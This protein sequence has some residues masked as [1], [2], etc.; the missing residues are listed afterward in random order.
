[1]NKLFNT[2]T[3]LSILVS[4]FWNKSNAQSC[5][6]NAGVDQTICVNSTMTL[7]GSSTGTIS[8]AGKWQFISGPNTPTITSPNNATTTVTGIAAGTYVF[9]YYAT[10]VLGGVVTD[11][12]TVFVDPLP[13]FSAGNDVAVC[14]SIAQLNGNLPS[15]A[16][17]V[18]SSSNINNALTT[19]FASPNSTTSNVSL[20]NPSNLCPKKFN[21]IWTVT[22]GGCVLKDTAIVTI[23][24]ASNSFSP[25]TDKT[26]CGATVYSTPEYFYGCG[27]SL[28]GTQL[29][30]PSISSISY[31]SNFSSVNPSN[32]SN[33]IINFGSLIVGTYT[34]AVE[35]KTC[36]GIVFRDTFNVTINSTIGVTNPNI[37][38]LEICPKNFDTVYYF[39]PTVNLL[40]GEVL[41]WNTTPKL[42]LPST[43]PSPNVQVIGNV[44]KIS[45][46]LHP[47][48]SSTVTWFRYFYEY[49]VSNGS[50]SAIRTIS[51]NLVRPLG[52]AT[53]KTQFLPCNTTSTNITQILTGPA[54]PIQYSNAVIVS[55][56]LGAADPTILY[57]GTSITASN[58]KPGKYVISFQYSD[59]INCNSNIGTAEINVSAT[60][61][62]SNAGTDQTLGCGVSSATFAGNTPPTFQTGA[63]QLVSG[64]MN[65]SLLTPSNP[66]LTVSGFSMSG[67][68][69]FRWVISG[70]TNCPVSSDEVRILV[71]LAPPSPVNAGPDTTICSG[72]PIVLIGTPVLPIETALWTQIG[73][74]TVFIV[75]PTSETTAITGVSAGTKDTFTYAKTN[76]C[77]TGKDTVII[78][79]SSNIGP[80]AATITTLDF[81]A[82]GGVT[83]LPIAA[84][85]PSSGTGTWSI[86]SG[87]SAI[88]AAPSLSSTSVN[89][90]GGAGIY[91]L[92]W[93]VS[94]AGGCASQTDILTISYNGGLSINAA[95][96][97]DQT[98][99]STAGLNLA[100][101][102]PTSPLLGLWTQSVGPSVNINSPSSNTSAVTGLTESVY[103][104]VWTVSAGTESSCPIGRDTVHI[105]VNAPPTVSNIVT[106][107]K[108]FCS[109][110]N[111]TLAISANSPVSG[112]GS[113]AL[114]QTPGPFT[115]SIGNVS[116]P[117]TV[118]NYSSGIT[119]AIW[120]ISNGA[121]PV[122]IDTLTV[123]AVAPISAGSNRSVCNQNIFNLTGSILGNGSATWTLVSGPTI[124]V[125]SSPN[126]RVTSV[127]NLSAGT[128]IFRYSVAHP[129]CAAGFADVTINNYAQPIAK[130]GLDKALC[131]VT[132][133][134]PIALIA[135][136]AGG[137]G[138][139]SV[140]WT[141]TLGAGTITFSPN[142]NS[143]I[144]TA[145]AN[146]FGL[147]QFLLT[148]SNAACISKDYIDVT[149]IKPTINFSFSALTACNKDFTVFASVPTSGYTFAWSF[150]TGATTT[151]SSTGAITNSFTRTGPNK[152]Y[153]TITSP[154]PEFCSLTDSLTIDVCKS[155]YPPIANNITA[156]PINSSNGPTQI[157]QLKASNPMGTPI[158]TYKVLTLPPTSQ[159]VL[160][161]CASAPAICTPGALTAVSIGSILTPAQ[162][163]SL[164]FDPVQT[165][166]GNVNFTYSAT[167]TNNLVSNVA[168]YSIPVYNNSPTTLNIRTAPVGN[169]SIGDLN[170]PKL[171]SA[172][173]DGK[174]DSFYISNIP[175]SSQGVLS[176]CS[177]GTEP[178]TGTVTP[179]TSGVVLTPAQALSLKFRPS[180]SYIGD[181]TF[182]YQTK[183]NNNNLSN[184]S[185]YSIPV[186]APAPASY[187]TNG[188]PISSNITTQNINNSS[189]PTPIPNLNGTDPDLG[190]SV[191]TYTIGSSV[192]NP[193]TEGTLYYC[194]S[195]GPG[196]SLT[197]VTAGGVLTTAQAA[198]LKFDPV[199]GFIGVA[200]FEYTSQDMSGLTSAPATYK[201]PVVNMPPVTNPIS[202]NPISNTK[203]SPTLLPPLFGYDVDGTI[204]SYNILDVPSASQGTLT[205]C[206]NGTNPCTGTV[207]SISA[208]LTGLT[209]V[210]IA[211]LKF[212]PN[213]NFTG[214]YVFHYS[215]VDNN[216]L[217]SQ[218]SAFT[219][220]VNA[221][222]TL[223]GEPPIAISYN[224]A[225]INS[226]STGIL[227]TSALMGTDPDGSVDSFIVTTISPANEGMLT[228]CVSPPSA[229]C[230][231]TL[232]VG[233]ALTPAQAATV[234]FTPNLNFTGVS[235]FNYVAKDNSGNISNTAT[236]TIPV[237]NEPP[238]SKNITNSAISRTKTTPT[239]L[240]PLSSTDPDGTVM[241]FKILTIP[242]ANEGVLSFCSTPGV[243]PTG[244]IPV[245]VGQIISPADIG[246]LAFTPASTNNS[247]VV[248]FLYSTVDN[249]G[250]ISNIAN[251]NIPFYNALP[252]PIGVLKFTTIKQG[253]NALIEWSI[254]DE[255]SNTKY[256]IQHSTNGIIWNKIGF[257]PST[258]TSNYNLL[259]TNL[260]YGLNYFRLKILD[261]FDNS[262]L[263]P[264]RTLFFDWNS[265]NGVLI[266]PNP[267]GDK[268][269]VT[270]NDGSNIYNLIISSNDGRVIKEFKGIVSG[271]A[272]DISQ[273][274]Q[275]FYL[276]TVIDQNGISKTIKLS[277]Y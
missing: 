57:S 245:A 236:V 169:T 252:L 166:T 248:S 180:S 54:Y 140:S 63:W 192:P 85:S 184:I 113:W 16:T 87:P 237:I 141:R 40:P 78:T 105:S 86:L 6:V 208:S 186:V 198:T 30:G 164:Y 211:T 76:A 37:A 260:P 136:T 240:F 229:G 103:E 177:N 130:A 82:S 172:D 178:C 125:F 266:Y 230:G 176:Y 13:I 99:C 114:I 165:F 24:N 124:A 253:R 265:E 106:T 267:A 59:Q 73:G 275:G 4:G 98:V 243:P 146:Q 152:I 91:K 79:N 122:S 182:N 162:S 202:I 33:A 56:P 101:T 259:H 196:C 52:S 123:E 204:A 158:S 45:N 191:L 121:C 93:T 194:I 41:T 175:N 155:I 227:L 143:A 89:L 9:Q 222:S 190:D 261:E 212:T 38:D 117:S 1:M 251:V 25:I 185:S 42:K 271:S 83:A 150:P 219:I 100:A 46:P 2:I 29:S 214:N 149:I 226:N 70:G 179:I 107:D 270:A 127:S 36:S 201:I 18:W 157:P 145:T 233:K 197:P 131:W 7:V 135:D 31:N 159:G 223:V 81:C 200:K 163:A 133:G 142:S 53:F 238:I 26:F 19:T 263:G 129:S 231:T 235:T 58:L 17:G 220:P 277:K 97:A 199:A 187:S 94:A 167:D 276:I 203:T 274:N 23:A 246:K 213:S 170:I 15:G 225:P 96:G 51:L 126:Q 221:F 128:Y 22:K 206:S 247:S 241:S 153:L 55:K 71:T 50:C 110:N 173:N 148:V 48:P 49:T 174:I 104:F 151:S 44:L 34:F 116:S 147:Q 205:Y 207:T 139:S 273:F 28:T 21:A 27:G 65:P 250:L 264:V 80:S 249:N 8:V 210:Q 14:G 61:G 171:I 269:N 189:G 255:E 69:T 195:P 68:Y 161:Y 256:V 138:T 215:A 257:Q 234:K 10:C 74:P 218:P 84:I 109:S 232:T 193:S 224:N 216:G 62:A 115:T 120:Q 262:K 77:G 119:K 188:P 112:V 254:K 168:S 3:V 95:A 181:F 209:A 66:S 35:A 217:Q 144:T 156:M 102:A 134:T 244:C 108:V 43:L 228:Y 64:P 32:V 258:G 72:S 92:Q 272:V 5:S 242:T 132:S 60:A 268:F 39:V 20:F 75:N 160:Y 11:N 137:V 154:S 183:D 118:L 12:V 67:V 88:I 90:T 47:D 239:T 111:G